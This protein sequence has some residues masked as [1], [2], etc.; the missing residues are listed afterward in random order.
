MRLWLIVILTLLA[1]QLSAQQDWPRELIDPAADTD[2]ADLL[3][4]MPCGAAMAFQKVSVPLDAT[5]PLAD[6]RV[7]LGQSRDQTGYSDY[8]LPAYLRGPFRD[9]DAGTT[10]YYI[11]RYELTHGQ[12]RVL[13]GDCAAPT[14]ADRL[15]QGG[16]GWFDAV[17]LTQ[18]YNEWL[19]KNAVGALP[20]V[21][22]VPAFLR[23]P[24][25]AEW[26]YATRGGARVDATQFPAPVFF[27]KGDLRDFARFQASGSSRGKLGPV[28]VRNPNPLGLFDVYGNA[29]ELMLEPFRLNAIGRSGGQVGGIVTR[30]GSV[31]ST[32]DQIYSA[33]RTEYPPYDAAKGTPLR[34]E[35][36]GVRL[37]LAAP[38]TTSDQRLNQ[39]RERWMDL[40][41]ADQTG[42]TVDPVARITTLIEA[43]IDP[44]RRDELD[45]LKLEFR[46]ARDRAQTALQQSARATLLAGAV[47]VDSLD[48]NAADIENKA[49]NIRLLIDLQRAGENSAVYGRQVEKHVA[50]IKQMRHVQSTYLLSF[51]AALETLTTDIGATDREAAYNVLREELSLSGR[52]K[53]LRT[54]DRFWEDLAVYDARPDINPTQLLKVALD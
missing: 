47:F 49:G 39:I 7:R 37:V 36:F 43:E 20:Q 38:I 12:Y 29:E 16:L 53:T 48:E 33:Q 23:L 45:N 17:T 25:E 6:R 1:C 28:G 52:D 2:P 11:A 4:P 42:A 9:D 21:D 10:Y 5:D 3:L 46:R 51:R 14:R 13:N 8:L 40:A 30:G 44:R 26:E 31:L 22:D 24:T 34:A 35:T 15:A 18:R 54:L 19:L 32:A 50:E 41:N 27:G